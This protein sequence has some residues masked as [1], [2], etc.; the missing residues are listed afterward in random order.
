MMLKKMEILLISIFFLSLCEVKK[1]SPLLL[2]GDQKPCFFVGLGT[3]ISPE[4]PFGYVARPGIIL[5]AIVFSFPHGH[6]SML[7][8]FRILWCSGAFFTQG[9]EVM[10][11]V[12]PLYSR[13]GECKVLNS[14]GELEGIAG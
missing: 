2:K 10:R 4:S 7:G 8:K 12:E 9:S 11:V 6:G 14:C 3:V 13:K 5:W 1:L